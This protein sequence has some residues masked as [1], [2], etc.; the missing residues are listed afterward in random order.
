[1]ICSQ[2]A[3][4]KA[5]NDLVPQLL[6]ALAYEGLGRV[7]SAERLVAQ[8]VKQHPD[9]SALMLYFL[10]VEFLISLH[11]KQVSA[12]AFRPVEVGVQEPTVP[13][14]MC[15]WFLCDVLYRS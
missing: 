12:R 14:V 9:T 10:L 3:A 2:S 4:D 15:L 1:M 8:L 6:L 11:V 5:P 13:K 7:D